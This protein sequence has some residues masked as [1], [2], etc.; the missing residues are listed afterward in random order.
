MPQ[1]SSF[2][3]LPFG[4]LQRLLLALH[5][6][7]RGIDDKYL[8]FFHADS[9]T[10]FV[11][12]LYHPQDKVSMADLVT[13]RKQLAWRGLLSEEAFDSTLSKASA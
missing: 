10:L 1:P 5:F 13:V 3:D 8:G 7:E 11:F 6:V 9:D 4:K 2:S 12:R